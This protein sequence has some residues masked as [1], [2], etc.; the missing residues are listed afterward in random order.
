[1]RF[2]RPLTCPSRAPLAIIL[3]STS[4]AAARPASSFLQRFSCKLVRGN[5][6]C[7]RTREA[8]ASCPGCPGPEDNSSN[9]SA[10]R[11]AR[12]HFPWSS[13]SSCRA[14]VRGNC[15]VYCAAQRAP[16][17]HRLSCARSERCR[18]SCPAL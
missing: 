3:S 8:R 4:P 13:S 10:E 17:T 7:S 9:S 16:G 12:T 18:C 1:M 11:S 15:A 14:V 2:S 6:S 5:R